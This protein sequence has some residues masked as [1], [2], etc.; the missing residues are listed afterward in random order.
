MFPGG[1]AEF[2]ACDKKYV[3]KIFLPPSEKLLWGPGPD[4]KSTFE[5][6]CM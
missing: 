2:D 4:K 3:L 1:G 5:V 6:I